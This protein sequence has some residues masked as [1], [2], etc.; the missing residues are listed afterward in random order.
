MPLKANCGLSV[1]QEVEFNPCFSLD[2][3]LMKVFLLSVA[4]GLTDREFH[5]VGIQKKKHTL[6][7]TPF[8]NGKIVNLEVSVS[9]GGGD[10]RRE[11]RLKC[12]RCHF[13]WNVD[14]VAVTWL[15]CG[16]S[17]SRPRWRCALGRWFWQESPKW[18][19]TTCKISWKSTSREAAM[20]EENSKPF[21]TTRRVSTP[22]RCSRASTPQKSSSKL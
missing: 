20:E 3:P 12:R 11:E 21:S 17:P 7:V 14:E 19:T 22:W 8:L 9:T 13:L 15:N 5:D 10:T 18:S 6:R 1:T 16:D 4:R 2:L